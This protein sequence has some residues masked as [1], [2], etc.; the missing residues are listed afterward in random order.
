MRLPRRPRPIS[1]TRP[2]PAWGQPTRFGSLPVGTTF[3]ISGSTARWT[4]IAFRARWVGEHSLR[5][6]NARRA[7]PGTARRHD[8]RFVEAAAVVVPHPKG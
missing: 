4:K 7:A 8:Y 3:A 2:P 1:P 6:M 5:P